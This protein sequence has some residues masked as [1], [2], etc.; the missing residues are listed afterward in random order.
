MTI[1]GNVRSTLVLTEN[2]KKQMHYLRIEV[3]SGF[4]QCMWTDVKALPLEG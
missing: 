3:Q 1:T 4:G 2:I